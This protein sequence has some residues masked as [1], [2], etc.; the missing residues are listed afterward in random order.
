MRPYLGQIEGVDGVSLGILLRH[1][2]YLHL[3][4]RKFAAL[5][6]GVQ[7]AAVVVEIGAGDLRRL[8]VGQRL[9]ALHGLEVPFHP[10]ALA[11]VVPQAVGVAGVAVHVAQ[12]GGNA[13]VGEQRGDLMQ[14]LRRQAPVVPLHGVVAQAGGR[15]A[16]LRV[17]EIGELER[18]AHE[19]HRCVVAHHVPVAFL[20]VELQREA[21]RVARRVGGAHLSG[22]GGKTRE[23]F[24]AIADFRK[25]AWRRCSGRYRRSPSTCRRRPRPWHARPAPAHARG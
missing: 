9:D 23:H 11:R 17:N 25:T 21:A 3:P 6:G 16:F 19:E 7:V 1:D 20:R 10:I 14:R 12:R 18:I 2:L 24:A 8:F 22:H 15:V 5:D 13:A 4:L